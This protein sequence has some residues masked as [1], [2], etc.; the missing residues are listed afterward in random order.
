VV[1]VVALVEVLY[2]DHLVL[3]ADGVSMRFGGVS[4]FRG[5]KGR[6]A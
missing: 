1:V 3:V 6:R 5:V 4:A 2:L